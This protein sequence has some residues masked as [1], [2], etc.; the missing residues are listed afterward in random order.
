M[1]KKETTRVIAQFREE[2]FHQWP[3]APEALAF[4]REP[5]RHVLHIRAELEVTE[6]REVEFI[7]LKSC[8]RA[9]FREMKV[10]PSPSMWILGEHLQDKED[11]L[12]AVRSI[13]HGEA[14]M[15]VIARA[16]ADYLGGLH[17][18]DRDVLVEVLEDGEN[19][20]VFER[21]IGHVTRTRQM[22][23]FLKVDDRPLG[24]RRL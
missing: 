2:Y 3:D 6:D 24:L 12:K 17:G 11:Y 19:G 21:R 4:L 20:A 16:L 5:H 1:I 8:L 22:G 13:Q 9:A 15:E 14:S 18:F 7:R 10:H 23:G